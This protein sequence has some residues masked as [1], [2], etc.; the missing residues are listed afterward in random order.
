MNEYSLFLKKTLLEIKDYKFWGTFAIN[1]IKI[2]YSRSKLGFY[3]SFV[4][5]FIWILALFVVFK[6]I[7]QNDDTSFLLYMSIGIIFFNF[8]ESS[9]SESSTLLIANR[10]LLLNI[11][12]SVFFFFLRNYYKNLV[13]FLMS[14]IIYLLQIIF[15]D[16]EFN[17]NI[18][19]LPLTFIIF[20]QTVFALTIIVGI[21]CTRYRDLIHLTHVAL[22]I[23]FIITPIFWMKSILVEYKFVLDFNPFYYLLE[24]IRNP[25]IGNYIEMKFLYVSLGIC[26]FSTVIAALLLFV[27]RN[28]IRHWL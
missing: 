20:A 2:K 23:F 13:V 3:W 26:L 11:N 28:E 8:I 4:N 19:Y 15:I 12:I 27:T 17:K 21:L 7:F 5:T 14:F 16:V 24:L 9:I 10:N 1:D 22:R 6:G 18:F 25:L